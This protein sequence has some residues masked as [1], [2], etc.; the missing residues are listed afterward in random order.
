MSNSTPDEFY[1]SEPEANANGY[2]KI[3]I[4]DK[5]YILKNKNIFSVIQR[6]NNHEY[7]GKDYDGEPCILK[8]GKIGDEIEM[9]IH[10]YHGRATNYI[11]ISCDTIQPNTRYDREIASASYEE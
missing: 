2:S 10:D 9:E 6:L 8:I 11:T 1:G 4:H 5:I 7:C 3:Q